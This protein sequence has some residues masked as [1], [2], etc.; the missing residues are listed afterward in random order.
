MVYV[1]NTDKRPPGSDANPPRLWK[2]ARRGWVKKA[3]RERELKLQFSPLPTP[4][5]TVDNQG[6]VCKPVLLPLFIQPVQNHFVMFRKLLKAF[7]RLFS[8]HGRRGALQKRSMIMY[9][10]ELGLTQKP[11]QPKTKQNPGTG[12]EGGGGGREQG[13][14]RRKASR[15][16]AARR[17]PEP[18]PRDS[19]P[20]LIGVWRRELERG[21]HGAG[22]S[23]RPGAPSPAREDTEQPRR[24]PNGP[25]RLPL[26][27]DSRSPSP[28]PARGPQRLPGRL[29]L[30]RP[31]SS[32]PR[33]DPAGTHSGKE[34]R[35]GP[36]RHLRRRAASPRR[37]RTY[38]EG[39]TPA[40]PGHAPTAL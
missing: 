30:R 9:T 4:L 22:G 33:P 39:R 1:S 11:L 2:G 12:K 24:P 23:G 32:P 13:W 15:A 21:G 25:P 29:S 6:D 8:L 36:A 35:P 37:T 7:H 27:P 5:P 40:T 10:H 19:E 3:G 14:G 34:E 26:G 18:R 20:D 16:A 38:R 31:P 17:G 28:G